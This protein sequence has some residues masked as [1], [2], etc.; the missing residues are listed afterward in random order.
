MNVNKPFSFDDP[1]QINLYILYG[2][3]SPTHSIQ[4]LPHE[5]YWDTEGK[6]TDWRSVERRLR[7]I[8]EVSQK[9]R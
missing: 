4:V 5:I 9:I 3:C 1:K 6:I 7:V 2:Y 8:R